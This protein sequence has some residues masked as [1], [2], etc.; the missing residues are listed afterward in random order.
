[1]LGQCQKHMYSFL[2]QS[3]GIYYGWIAC[4]ALNSCAILLLMA[5]P[6][7][8]LRFRLRTFRLDELVFVFALMSLSCS[9]FLA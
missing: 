5:R 1:L 3:H 9:W 8:F 6:L 4:E 7:L 2:Q